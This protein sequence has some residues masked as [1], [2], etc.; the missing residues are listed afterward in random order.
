MI[1][2]K[3][4]T[5]PQCHGIIE[6]MFKRYTSIVGIMFVVAVLGIIH[7]SSPVVRS[8]TIQ[9]SHAQHTADTTCQ[10]ACQVTVNRHKNKSPGTK[11]DNEA[12]EPKFA[13]MGTLP[14]ETVGVGLLTDTALWRQS[15]WLPPD[16]TL[17][18]GYYSSSL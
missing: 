14:I 5:L 1:V 4:F 17:L 16:T 18:S 9:G 6:V 7:T 3:L 13:F 15:S 12:P 8:L 11:K 2:L 10:V